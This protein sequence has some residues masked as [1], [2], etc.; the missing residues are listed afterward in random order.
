MHEVAY[1]NLPC[2]RQRM[3]VMK[4]GDKYLPKGADSSHCATFANVRSASVRWRRR[5]S[6]RRQVPPETCRRRLAPTKCE[7][8]GV[9]LF[10]RESKTTDFWCATLDMFNAKTVVDFS[11]GTGALACASM[12]RGVKYLGE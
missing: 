11:P 12:S 10:W 7:R 6:S 1:V 5:A 2:S 8:G 4:R 9:P 3:P